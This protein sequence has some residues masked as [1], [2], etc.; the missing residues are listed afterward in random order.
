MQDAYMANKFKP[1]IQI[2][3]LITVITT[4]IWIGYSSPFARHAP[5][6]SFPLLDGRELSLDSL[7]GKTVLVTFWAS[8]CVECRKEMPDLIALYNELSGS[9]F[10]IIGVAMPYDPPNRV[11][12]TSELMD[13]PYPVALD[14]YGNAV[15]AFGDVAVTPSSFLISPGGEIV[16]HQVGSLDTT[17]LRKRV[18]DLLAAEQHNI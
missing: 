2:V 18:T 3:T 15:K 1:L 4:V 6:I 10:E 16:V 5:D 13:I 17:Q 9:G 14:I 7:A 8:T 11:L 12:E